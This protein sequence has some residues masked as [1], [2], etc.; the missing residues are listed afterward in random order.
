MRRRRAAYYSRNNSY[1]RSYNAS[2]A[3]AE[4][5][6]PRTRAAAA[7]GLS[8]KAFDAGCAACG[9]RATEWHHVGKYA[10]MVD[11]YDTE[12]LSASAEFWTGAAPHVPRLYQLEDLGRDG[13]QITWVPG[14]GEP[15]TGNPFE[16]TR[17]I[18]AWL[19]KD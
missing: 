14:W 1:S 15:I 6:L 9:Y 5:R 17:R 10:N 12:E 18:Q 7:L 3:E 4:G 8:T 2:C 16:E 11:Y 13:E 19:Q